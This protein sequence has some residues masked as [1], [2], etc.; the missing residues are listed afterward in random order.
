MNAED[1]LNIFTRDN[2]T[3][4]QC[5]KTLG[6]NGLQ[7]AHRIKQ[8][9]GSEENIRKYIFYNHNLTMT[10]SWIRKNIINHP[11]NLVTTCCLKCNDKQN[12]FFKPVE[13]D[14]LLKQIIDKVL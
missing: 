2:F 11:D 13:R 8:G 14:R 10:L 3:C 12:I 6:I 5:G 7:I 9:N 4:Q 1:R